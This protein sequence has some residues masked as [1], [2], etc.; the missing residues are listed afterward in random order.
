MEIPSPTATFLPPTEALP[1]SESASPTSMP[2]APS[3]TPNVPTV[4]KQPSP[5]ATSIPYACQI[6]KQKPE[7]GKI[8]KPGDNFDAVWTVK[9]SGTAIW[10]NNEVD[11]RYD[12]GDKLHQQDIY[13]LPETVK[14]GESIDLV[15]DMT[16]PDDEGKYD[17]TW[18]LRRGA[19]LI[20]TMKI[21]IEVEK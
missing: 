13:D 7:D 9:N 15:V 1:T 21:E 18:V 14:P 4:T 19:H 2:S 20:C 17:T 5:T 16:A 8:F 11:Y 3:N 10:D 6:T 12:S